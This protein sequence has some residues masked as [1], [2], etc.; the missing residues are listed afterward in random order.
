MMSLVIIYILYIVYI[1][2]LYIY[3]YIIIKR[4]KVYNIIYY[5]IIN[6]RR[7]SWQTGDE[8]QYS[9]ASDSR[10]QQQKEAK[11]Q[12]NIYIYISI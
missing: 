1:Y 2:I 6:K 5:Y 9:H 10:A 4:D 3:T 8:A 12:H 7:A 11:K